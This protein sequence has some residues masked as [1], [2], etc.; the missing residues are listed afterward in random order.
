[1]TNQSVISA[2]KEER[3]K[4]GTQIKSSAGEKIGNVK[5]EIKEEADIL[6]CDNDSPERRAELFS[7]RREVVEIVT[8]VRKTFTCDKC[9][10]EYDRLNRLQLHKE[11]M[12]GNPN[13]EKRVLGPSKALGL[14]RRTVV[15]QKEAPERLAPRLTQTPT[16]TPTPTPT[17]R[18]IP[19]PPSNPSPWHALLSQAARHFRTEDAET[20]RKIR[21]KLP[22]AK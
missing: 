18:L 1:M 4:N 6:S 2:Q 19:R 7:P 13:R 10:K 5:V 14:M 11:S 3:G 12:H 22:P 20:I 21:M 15:L 9:N 16:S 17:P 8:R